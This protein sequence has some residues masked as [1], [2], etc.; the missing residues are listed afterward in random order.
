MGN[1]Q[2]IHEHMHDLAVEGV[3]T[4]HQFFLSYK[5]R[6]VQIYCKLFL[7]VFLFQFI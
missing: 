6:N 2:E 7:L 3:G 1:A 4:L 5:F